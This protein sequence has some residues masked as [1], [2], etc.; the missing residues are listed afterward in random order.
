MAVPIQR[1]AH[2]NANC[3]DLERSLRFYGDFVGLTRGAHTNPPPQ[4]GAGFGLPGRIQWD[5]Y[6]MNDSRGADSVCLDL[7]QWRHPVPAG[8]PY[9]EPNHLGMFRLCLLAPDLDALYA[10]AQELGVPCESPPTEV[11]VI[12]EQDLVV[13]ALFCRDPDGT[14][15]EFIEQ[16]GE[17]RLIHVN[18]NCSDLAVSSPWYQEVLGF[19]IQSTSRPGPVSGEAFGLSGKVE[20]QADFLCPPGDPRFII[21]L[22]EWKEPT[23]VGRPYDRANH[24]GLYR[25]AFLVSDIHACHA[26]LVRLGVDTSPPVFLDMGPE[27]PVDGVWALFFPDPDGTCLELIQSPV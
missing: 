18:V 14:L 3:T 20:W 4:P 5:A 7:L 8:R 10:R 15:I 11:S 24:L 17:V 1:V 25:M 26:E 23:P 13:R 16:P 19:E 6:M 2:V 21:D 27:I 12:P 9:Q 22:L